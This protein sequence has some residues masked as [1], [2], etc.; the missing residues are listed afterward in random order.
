MQLP[1]LD[2]LNWPL[3]RTLAER[4]ARAAPADEIASVA[5]ENLA[6]PDAPHRMLAVYLLGF[7]AA[8][9]PANLTW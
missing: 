7:T 3:I 6:A 1:P 2:A 9:R 4:L 8:E 5:E